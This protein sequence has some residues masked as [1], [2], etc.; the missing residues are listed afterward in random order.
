GVS[1]YGYL[2]TQDPDSPPIAAHRRALEGEQVAFES[3]LE[4]RL[5]QSR[6]QPLR[7]PQGA[8]VGVLGVAVDVTER[9]RAEQALREAEELYRCLVQSVKAILWRSPPGSLTFSFVSQEA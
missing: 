1:L 3:S 9:K 6:V 5:F 2:G 8:I 4:G 7:D